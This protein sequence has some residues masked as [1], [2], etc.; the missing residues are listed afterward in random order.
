MATDDPS[1]EIM[2]N[3]LETC[4]NGCTKD[5]IIQE[6]Y[7]SHDQLR[8]TTVEMVDRELLHYIEAR[9]I[10]ITTDKG[11]IFLNRRQQSNTIQNISNVFDKKPEAEEEGLL[12]NSIA[13][14]QNIIHR[15][16]QLW[17]NRHQNQ[18]AIKLTPDSET[19]ATS[20]KDDSNIFLAATNPNEDYIRVVAE[21]DY[22]E[23]LKHGW[24][25]TLGHLIEQYKQKTTTIS[26]QKITSTN[27]NDKVNNIHR[28]G[29]NNSNTIPIRLILYIKCRYCDSEF[30]TEEEKNEHELELHI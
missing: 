9:G 19:L 26:L 2:V 22:F 23:P 8:R 25:Y 18:F 12:V 29:N 16:I 30:N 21:T 10:Y 1:A 15:K 6:T 4:R 3:I 7:L 13:S 24:D 28:E 17:T 11:Y 20:D 5:K 14:K 27:N